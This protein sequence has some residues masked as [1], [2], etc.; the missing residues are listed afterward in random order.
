VANFVRSER[1]TGSE[2][3]RNTS[4]AAYLTSL[5][6]KIQLSSPH[7]NLVTQLKTLAIYTRSFQ[8]EKLP[9]LVAQQSCLVFG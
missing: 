4:P 6:G 8:R 9:K 3:K 1:E 5:R 7:M 2:Y